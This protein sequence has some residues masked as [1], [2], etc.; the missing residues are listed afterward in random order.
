MS[1]TLNGVIWGGI[2]ASIVPVT[3]LV[4]NH[5]RWKKEAKLEYLKSERRRLEQLFSETLENLADGMD[6]NS[7]PTKMLSDILILMPKNISDRFNLWMDEKDKDASK[8]RFALF[9]ISLE[10]KKSLAMIDD[11]IREL[12]MKDY[13]ALLPPKDKRNFWPHS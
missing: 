5:F 9:D 13:S 2:I 10:M 4:L 11:Q 1:E 6:K 7:Y 12:I 3:T 8:G